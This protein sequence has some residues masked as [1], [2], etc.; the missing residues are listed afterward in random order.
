ML[1][2]S[3]TQLLP[4]NGKE[5]SYHAVPVESSE[6][7]VNAIADVVEAFFKKS[8]LIYSHSICG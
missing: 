4:M 5:K 1:Q 7:Y 2:L 8:V 6:F 3:S